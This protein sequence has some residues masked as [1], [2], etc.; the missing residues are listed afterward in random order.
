M[1]KTD[2]IKAELA[3]HFMLELVPPLIRKTLVD[4]ARF[5]E[6]Y[7]LIFAPHILISFTEAGVFFNRSDLFLAIREALSGTS[8]SEVVDTD[9]KAWELSLKQNEQYPVAELIRDNKCLVF[10]HIAALSP[11]PIMRLQVLEFLAA[12]VGLPKKRRDEW[13]R[14]F[15]SHAPDDDEFSSFQSDLANTPVQRAQTIGNEID[16]QHA[17][18]S[19]FVPPS[20]DYFQRLVGTCRRSSENVFI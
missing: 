14:L 2:P 19:S 13:Q 18:I 15:E 10:P 4:D 12:T 1:K 3:A 17:Q 11:D 6:E 8:V 5:R 16:K 7:G 20:R 9:A